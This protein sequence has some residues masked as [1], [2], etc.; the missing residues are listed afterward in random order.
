MSDREKK[1]FKILT[2]RKKLFDQYTF[3][4]KTTKSR[5]TTIVQNFELRKFQDWQEPQFLK[6][7]ST[8]GDKFT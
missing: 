6:K 1:N 5:H 8:L 3:K 4:P 7:F 2:D